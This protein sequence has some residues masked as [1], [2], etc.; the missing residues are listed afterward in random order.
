[1]KTPL[2]METLLVGLLLLCGHVFPVALQ[3]TNLPPFWTS[4]L[5]D[6]ERT[7]RQAKK[8]ELRVLTKSAGKRD[9]Y[10]VTYGDKPG[11]EI[12]SKL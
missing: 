5:S 10:L 4:R 9:V 1:M 3:K 6:V 11:L 2:R 8:G 12:R 7:V